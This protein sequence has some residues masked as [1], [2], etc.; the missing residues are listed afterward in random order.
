MARGT[1]DSYRD[2]DIGHPKLSGDSIID[3]NIE[4]SSEFLHKGTIYKYPKDVE[5]ARNWLKRF[6]FNNIHIVST[7]RANRINGNNRANKS[8]TKQ[9][10]TLIKVL[11]LSD[12]DIEKYIANGEWQVSLGGICLCGQ[13]MSLLGAIEGSVSPINGICLGT[14]NIL[15]KE[16]STNIDDYCI[17]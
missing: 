8:I 15:I 17:F 14:I 11:P 12:R 16:L 10:D 5:M 9:F 4:V 7:Y 2:I 13:G 1:L 6:S 3:I